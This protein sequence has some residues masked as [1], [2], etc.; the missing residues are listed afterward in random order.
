M[1][2]CDKQ[3]DEKIEC[4]GCKLI[5][6]QCEKDK[7]PEGIIK[8]NGGWFL[9]H[10]YGPEGFLGWLALSPLKHRDQLCEMK[11]EMSA[12]G[13]H[14]RDVEIALRKYWSKYFKKDHLK[15]IYV[16]YF[17]ESKDY[18]LHF[19]LIPR[20]ESFSC[21]FSTRKPAWDTAKLTTC[22]TEFPK[23]YRIRCR[24]KAL[25]GNTEIEEMQKVKNLMAFLKKN[26]KGAKWLVKPK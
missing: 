6:P 15:K 5:N 17:S 10:Y 25:M 12:L 11:K 1:E 22:W 24:E 3:A 26:I 9:N 7:R 18:H 21:A 20:T 23:K 4:K 19:H 8:L 13:G 16:I 14:I 2:S